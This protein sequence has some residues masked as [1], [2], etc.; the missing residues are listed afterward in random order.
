MVAHERG[1]FQGV[2]APRDAAERCRYGGLLDF[3]TRGDPPEQPRLRRRLGSNV[4]EPKN[5]SVR[6]TRSRTLE[7]GF[8]RQ[9]VQR[10]A[11]VPRL[12][13][14]SETPS[15]PSAGIH[16][17]QESEQ[18]FAAAAHARHDLER[19]RTHDRRGRAG[20]HG[21]RLDCKT[22]VRTRD[23]LH[24]R[25]S[26][27]GAEGGNQPLGRRLGVPGQDPPRGAQAQDAVQVHGVGIRP[28]GGGS[29]P[30]GRLQCHWLLILLIEWAD[31]DA[32]TLGLASLLATPSDKG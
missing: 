32:S 12:D 3:R 18:L 2:T 13:G 25:Q 23:A 10:S 27:R 9:Y 21:Q 30:F 16:H 19:A 5:V 31:G 1:D 14:P 22:R 17:R 15:P 6:P 26:R 24:E 4:G 20:S 11:G 7:G 8:A 29:L 28:R